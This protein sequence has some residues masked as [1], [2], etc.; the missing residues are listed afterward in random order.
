[1]K[2]LFFGFYA[3]NTQELDEL[4]KKGLIVVDTN[5]LLNLYRLPTTAR[6]ELLGVLDAFKDRLWIPHHVALEFQRRRLTVIA[7]ERKS[8]EDALRLA[9]GLVTDL[10]AKVDTLQIDKRGVGVESKPLLDDLE[11][12]NAKLV[13]AIEVVHASQLDISASDPIRN[14]L[15]EILQGRVGVGPN[16]Q[17]ELDALVAG[18]DDRFRDQIPPGFADAEKEKNPAEALLVHDHLRY[19]RK[20]G[21]LILWR[22][23]MAHVK[24]SGARAVLLVT[25][26]KKEDWWWREQG[27]TIGPH[28]ELIREMRREGGAE[29]F[30][31]YSSVQFVEH[32]SRYSNASVSTQSV[33]ELRSVLESIPNDTGARLTHLENL[34]LAEAAAP[35]KPGYSLF[36]GKDHR[37]IETA[38]GNWLMNNF[39]PVRENPQAFPDFVLGYHD[40]MEGF[41]VKTVERW[42]S[43]FTAKS[44]VSVMA[45]GQLEQI[46]GNL[47]RFTLIVVLSESAYFELLG[48]KRLLDSIYERA[49]KPLREFAVHAIVV[50]TILGTTFQPL[51]YVRRFDDDRV[52]GREEAVT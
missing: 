33:D 49:Q 18:G 6:D 36:L 32:A 43:L 8:T 40:A 41:E 44:I 47:S 39:G 13:S 34:L 31:M 3:P 29:I 51:A 15:D 11:K 4:W 35:R 17:G 28:P 12:A 1:V 22:Q 37:R 21:D 30:W 9:K 27:K 38:V 42:S 26:D 46:E 19:Q 7:S 23:T 14:R 2:N 50:G 48:E 10:K 25:A 5:V 24:K 20:F 16:A 45:R 52:D